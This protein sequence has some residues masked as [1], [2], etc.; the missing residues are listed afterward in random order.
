MR[1]ISFIIL[2]LAS[3]SAQIITAQELKSFQFYNKE[4]DSVAFRNTVDE[5]SD[6]DV[7]LFGEFH[8]NSI[9]HWLELKLAQALHQQKGS[10]LVLG[11]EMLERHQQEGLDSLLAD[12]WKAEQF[13]DSLDLWENFKTDY[14]PL[15][16]QAKKHNLKFVATN[17]PRNYAALVARSGLDTLDNFP[18]H[19]KHFFAHTPV[20]VDMETPGYRGILKM[21]GEHSGM[22]REPKQMV[23]AQALKDAT[24]AESILYNRRENDLFLHFNGNYHSKAHGGI[25]W[26]LKEHN[27]DLKIAV[28]TVLQADDERLTIPEKQ[29]GLPG[30][31]AS[32]PELTEFNLV[33]PEDMNKSY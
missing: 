11:A 22:Q 31:E 29:E 14:S 24:M 30:Q 8:D 21:M 28:I 27:A 17:V 9:N 13:R 12:N 20:K 32:E 16:E 15:V 7:V 4:G 1:K 6:Y 25:Y 10:N 5:L 3:L 18:E 26:Y 33:L 19:E 2:L 23:E